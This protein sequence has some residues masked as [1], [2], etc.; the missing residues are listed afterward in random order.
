MTLEKASMPGVPYRELPP[1]VPGA[2]V[3]EGEAGQQQAGVLRLVSVP[4][5]ILAGIDLPA[6]ERRLKGDRGRSGKDQIRYEP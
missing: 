4:R 5:E 1:A 3:A 2:L 6:R